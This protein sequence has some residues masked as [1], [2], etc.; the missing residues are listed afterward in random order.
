MVAFCAVVISWKCDMALAIV[1]HK[2]L[3]K[4]PYQ[5]RER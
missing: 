5:V 1:L 4:L 3:G 2:T